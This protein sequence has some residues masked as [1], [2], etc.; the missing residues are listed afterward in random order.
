MPAPPV[1][2]PITFTLDAPDAIA[3]W[4]P[5][6]AWFLAIPQL[7][8]VSVIGWVAGVCAVAAWFVVLITGK[9]PEGLAG[10]LALAVRAQMRVSAYAMFLK[11]EY[12][13]F[14]FETTLADPGDDPRVRLEVASELEGRNRLTVFFRGLL[15]LPQAIVLG[16]VGLAASIVV[17]VAMFAVLFTGAWPAGMQRFVVGFLR[18]NARVL[19]YYYLLT[20]EYPPFSLD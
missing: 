6:V 5:F 8:V 13:P 4:R 18:W 15:I 10:V 9:L 11:E 1:P 3:R 20:D 14:S 12:P 19:G 7:I 16:F 2:Y 17:L